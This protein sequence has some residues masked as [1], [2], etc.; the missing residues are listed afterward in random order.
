MKTAQIS[1]PDCRDLA[2]DEHTDPCPCPV[3]GV[4][5]SRGGM[6][7]RHLYHTVRY[8]KLRIISDR[9]RLVWWR[10]VVRVNDLRIWLAKRKAQR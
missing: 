7:M 2:L 3:S 10:L 6:T 8:I 5:Y 4:V 9:A 1:A